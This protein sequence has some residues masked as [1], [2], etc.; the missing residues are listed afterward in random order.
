MEQEL[1]RVPHIWCPVLEM[2]TC[3]DTA[4]AWFLGLTRVHSWWLS[5]VGSDGFITAPPATG[6]AHKQLVL[7]PPPSHLLSGRPCEAAPFL[8]A[9]LAACHSDSFSQW[10]SILSVLV[11]FLFKADCLGR[12]T[13]FLWSF[14]YYSIAHCF[15]VLL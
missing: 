13:S 2:T 5:S 15:Q 10:V 1:L 4:I 8:P 9:R 11:T 14:V 3:T 12:C 7:S 6:A